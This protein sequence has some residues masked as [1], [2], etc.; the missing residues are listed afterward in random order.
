MSVRGKAK[1]LAVS[2]KRNTP[3]VE[4]LRWLNRGVRTVAAKTHQAQFLAEWTVDNP[5]YFDH[6]IDQYYLWTK[7][8]VSFPWE[9]GVFSSLA[10]SDGSRVLD[11]CCG[12]GF[13]AYHFYSLRATQVTA[14]DFDAEAIKW[15]R[16]NFRIDNVRWIE[17]DIRTQIPDGPFDNIVWDAA[18][19]HF[20]E[21]E[22]EGLM[23][24]IKAVMTPGGTL[25]GY[26]IVES[27]TGQKSL[28]QHEY[29]FSSRED[30]ARFL[31]PH[32]RNVQ[33]FSTA[34]PK[35]E[36]LYFY[37]SDGPLPFEREWNLEI[38]AT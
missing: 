15:A 6:F 10:L 5:E 29:E 18:I 33:V 17:G 27:P 35:R 32:F 3:L 21:T 22:I 26:T 19:E 34:Y 8:R 12:D 25:S 20:T 30:L 2:V 31:S 4:G 7:T 28:H 37:A 36:N 14:I 13:N 9:R 16:R 11:F 23:A 24:R 38:R 1:K